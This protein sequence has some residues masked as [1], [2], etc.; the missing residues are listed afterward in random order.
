MARVR[1]YVKRKGEAVIHYSIPL[2]FVNR[3]TRLKWQSIKFIF[4]LFISML[5]SCFVFSQFNYSLVGR[6]KY[7]GE[8]V[9]GATVLLLNKD[10]INL[11]VGFC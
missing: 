8:I 10:S 9:N 5:M 11:F 4:L 1:K 3:V 6:L 7:Q 2:A